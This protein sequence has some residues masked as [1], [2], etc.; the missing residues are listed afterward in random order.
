MGRLGYSFCLLPQ[1]LNFHIKNTLFYFFVLWGGDGEF[2][3]LGHE[4]NYLVTG[5]KT[6]NWANC[7]THQDKGLISIFL[8]IIT[9]SACKS[10]FHRTENILTDT[11]NVV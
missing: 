7:T 9:S 10:L 11:K 6:S 1:D 8:N 4:G 5:M 3:F 2:D